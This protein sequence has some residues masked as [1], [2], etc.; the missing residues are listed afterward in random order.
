MG[1]FRKLTQNNPPHM[2]ELHSQYVSYQQLAREELHFMG[3]LFEKIDHKELNNLDY[4][5]F[6]SNSLKYCWAE[7]EAMAHRTSARDRQ[8]F[9]YF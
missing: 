9:A 8:E 1:L 6:R 5:N 7:L 4:D 3:V 2:K